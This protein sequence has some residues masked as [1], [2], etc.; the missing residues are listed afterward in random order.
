MRTYRIDDMW[1]RLVGLQPDDRVQIIYEWVKT[2]HV[3][4]YEF[5]VLLEKLHEPREIL[6]KPRQPV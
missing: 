2:G 4:L 3:S 5:R 1:D 6:G